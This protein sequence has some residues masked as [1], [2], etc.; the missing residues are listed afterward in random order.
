MTIVR[1]IAPVLLALVSPVIAQVSAPRAEFVRL[2]ETSQY[3]ENYRASAVVSARV[4]GARAQ[5]SDLE[6]ARLMK[7]VAETDLTDAKPCL[8]ALIGNEMTPEEA[9]E[10][11]SL[12]ESKV[13]QKI[14]TLSR[15]IM[16]E[17]IERGEVVRLPD[18]VWAT[19]ERP[20]VAAI[21]QNEAFRKFHSLGTKRSFMEG[22]LACYKNA[23]STK[24]PGVKF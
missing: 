19:D 1:F 6:Y 7:Y 17:T 9:V 21:Y 20:K 18:D 13:G 2:V 3:V 16:K 12:Y 14:I 5:G 24:H 15:R 4:F 8:A 10:V 11:A 22:N 23:L